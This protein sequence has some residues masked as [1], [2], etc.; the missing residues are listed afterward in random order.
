MHV[1]AAYAG[2]A[3]IC[4]E[5]RH[6]LNGI[7]VNDDDHDPDRITD[8]NRNHVLTPI[9]TVRRIVQFESTQMAVGQF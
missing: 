5:F 2:S 7:E 4:P 8:E 9:H 6:L 3:F 1:D